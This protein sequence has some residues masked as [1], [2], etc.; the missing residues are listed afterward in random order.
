MNRTTL[1]NQEWQYATAGDPSRPALLLLHGFTGSH[2][3]WNGLMARWASEYFVIAPDLPGHGKTAIPDTPQ[4]LSMRVTAE[5]LA[6]LLDYL[7]IAKAAV[8]GYSMGGR[9]ALYFAWRHP[10]LLWALVLES[11]SPGLSREEDRQTRRHSDRALAD[12]LEEKG[13]DWF[14]PYWADQALFRSQS[15]SVRESENRIR[16]TQSPYG[17]AQSLRGAGTGEQEPLWEH[18]SSLLMP[19]LLVTGTLDHKFSATA[20]QMSAAIQEVLWVPVSEAGHTVHGEQP[21]RFFEV[22]DSFLK[23]KQPTRPTLEE[24]ARTDAKTGRVNRE[25]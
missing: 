16:R 6:E 7:S 21:E 3:S 12:T 17:L 8:L 11:A 22:V 18:L 14:I 10:E 20:Q 24:A 23:K 25:L 19:V 4:D 1:M 9:L 2:A 5:R 15:A 13:L